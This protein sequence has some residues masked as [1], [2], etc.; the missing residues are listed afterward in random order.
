MAD[1]YSK[2]IQTRSRIKNF[3]CLSLF[4]RIKYQ[5]LNWFSNNFEEKRREIFKKMREILNIPESKILNI[6][7]SSI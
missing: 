5:Y 3:S 2:N 4:F 6:P 7:K 1:I